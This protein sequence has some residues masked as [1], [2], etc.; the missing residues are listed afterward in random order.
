M[1]AISVSYFTA[2]CPGGVVEAKVAKPASA[3]YAAGIALSKGFGLPLA[4]A[5]L[6]LADII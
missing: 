4:A 6:L 5:T 2:S 1:A 3:A